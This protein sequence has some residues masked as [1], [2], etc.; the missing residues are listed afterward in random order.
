MRNG[1]FG[2]P[3]IERVVFGRPCTEALAEAAERNGAERVFFIASGTLFANNNPR[4]R[5][6]A[7]RGSRFAAVAGTTRATTLRVAI[8]DAATAAPRNGADVY[9]KGSH[10]YRRRGAQ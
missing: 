1:V 10:R 9:P 7:A 8:G 2:Y 6:K 4:G 5:L 3:A